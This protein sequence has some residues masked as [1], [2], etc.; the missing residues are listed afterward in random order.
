MDGAINLVSK[1]LDKIFFRSAG[2]QK[3]MLE[4]LEEHGK[5]LGHLCE[6]DKFII[7]NELV[8]AEKYYMR[9]GFIDDD[10]YIRLQSIA[11]RYFA[12]DGNGRGK[13]AWERIEEVFRRN[14]CI[15]NRKGEEYARR[16]KR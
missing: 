14:D 16:A 1:I 3:K 5:Q 12:M 2:R 7:Q 11:T 10:D 4:L 9:Q 8:R 6:N 15:N 13:L